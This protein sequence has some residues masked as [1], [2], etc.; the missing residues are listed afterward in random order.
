MSLLRAAARSP[1]R[2]SGREL[3]I[4]KLT[5]TD[6]DDGQQSGTF[7]AVRTARYIY[8]ENGTGEIELYD[9]GS[10]PYELQNQDANP[11]YDAVEAALAARLAPLRS[12]SG[13]SCRQSR[14]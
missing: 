10:D 14:R 12:C 5:T 7:A 11:A 6:D 8:V 4:E 9:L 13:E 3:L 1:D 2:L